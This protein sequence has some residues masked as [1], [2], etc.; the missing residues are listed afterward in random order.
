MNSCV[1]IY[2]KNRRAPLPREDYS[3]PPL[4]SPVR[5]RGC[6]PV[7][8]HRLVSLTTDVHVKMTPQAGLENYVHA[9]SGI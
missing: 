9:E 4:F 5:P 6:I 1:V 7:G 8:S 3:S 2:T